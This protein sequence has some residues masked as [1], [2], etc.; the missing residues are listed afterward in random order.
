MGAALGECAE[1]ERRMRVARETLTADSVVG[2]D[3]RLVISTAMLILCT[4]KNEKPRL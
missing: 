3:S 2:A 1:M 4:R